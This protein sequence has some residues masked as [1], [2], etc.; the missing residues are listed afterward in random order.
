[1]GDGE[2]PFQQWKILHGWGMQHSNVWDVFGCLWIA[3]LIQQLQIKSR[4]RWGTSGHD[5]LERFVWWEP[6]YTMLSVLDKEIIH[7]GKGYWN[8]I[9]RGC[10]SPFAVLKP[11]SLSAS[12]LQAFALLS[13][14]RNNPLWSLF[15]CD[16]PDFP[17]WP[18][19]ARHPDSLVFGKTSELL[20]KIQ[21]P[22]C[23]KASTNQSHPAT[24]PT[25]NSSSD[26][27]LIGDLGSVGKEREIYKLYPRWCTFW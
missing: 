19:Q 4:N 11:F 20:A 6:L 22:S 26:S 2:C 14:N 12:F 10:Y 21:S 9:T 13:S 1:M 18:E 3:R 15:T 17:A 25:A 23:K 7:K 27:G 16:F 5:H 8:N 24:K